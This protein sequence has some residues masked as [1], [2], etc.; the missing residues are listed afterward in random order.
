MCTCMYMYV[1]MYVCKRVCTYV[2]VHV[3]IHRASLQMDD[4][5][6]LPGMLATVSKAA[7]SLPQLTLLTDTFTEVSFGEAVSLLTAEELSCTMTAVHMQGGD[8]EEEEDQQE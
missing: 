7:D 1:C 6:E 5:R 8:S 2:Y 4:L 3:C